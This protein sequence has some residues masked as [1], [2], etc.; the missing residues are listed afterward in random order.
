V[1][2]QVDVVDTALA[3]ALERASAAGEWSTVA[4]LAGELAARRAARDAVAKPGSNDSAPPRE[5]AP[6]I[7]LGERRRER[8]DGSGHAR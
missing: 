6:V 4:T 3:S 2:A 7:D 8:D 1:G 5:S